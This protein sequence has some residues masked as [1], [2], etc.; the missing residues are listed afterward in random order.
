MKILGALHRD[1][2]ISIPK[3]STDL[4]LNLSVTYSRIK[5]LIRRGII[6]RYTLEINEAKLGLPG[7]G[8]GGAQPGPE[9]EGAGHRGAH[10]APPGEG[11]HRGDGKVR[12]VP[13]AQG[14]HDR[15]AAQGDRRTSSGGYPGVT[16]TETFVEVAGRQPEV[17]YNLASAPRDPGL[18]PLS[19]FL[20]VLGRFP[21]MRRTAVSSV[22]V[23]FVVCI[24]LALGIWA[25]LGFYRRRGQAGP[26]PG[27]HSRGALRHSHGCLVTAPKEEGRRTLTRS[28]S[29]SSNRGIW[30]RTS[31]S[32]QRFIGLDDIRE[33][34]RPLRPP[35]PVRDAGEAEAG[36]GR[37]GEG[38]GEIPLRGGRARGEGDGPEVPAI[39]RGAHAP[40]SRSPRSSTGAW[41]RSSPG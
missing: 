6:Q 2:S 32:S 23:T 11:A 36:A 5:R 25:L 30:R 34:G 15:G 37:E 24:A 10:E 29:T 27:A 16:H 9:A 18:A 20:M 13:L 8:G 41:V 19:N 12:C 28:S 7:G 26:R 17:S 31:E 40:R 35:G 38:E 1:A 3:L 21:T 14:A 39:L 4:G 33:C 22:E